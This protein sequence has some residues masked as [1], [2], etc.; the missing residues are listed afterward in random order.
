MKKGQEQAL[1]LYL[2]AQG[3][4]WGEEEE[5]EED[6]DNLCLCHCRPSLPGQS[7]LMLPAA[8]V[9]F[10]WSSAF[11]ACPLLLWTLDRTADSFVD[12]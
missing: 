9:N 3:R 11:S 10:P 5:E 6:D 12:D 4:T 7:S 1:F 2:T 8:V